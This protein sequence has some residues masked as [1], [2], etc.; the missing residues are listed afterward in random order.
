MQKRSKA[1]SAWGWSTPTTY[2]HRFGDAMQLLCN[3]R[4]P[5]EQ[6]LLAWLNPRSESF[7]LQEFACEHGPSW[8]QGIAVI[9]TARLLADQPGHQVQCPHDE[10]VL[11]TGEL[12][13]TPRPAPHKRPP[14]QG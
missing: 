6:M 4:R 8:A 13:V 10:H 7:A 3:G 2:L 1:A 12:R 14:K 5:D 11:D 9:D